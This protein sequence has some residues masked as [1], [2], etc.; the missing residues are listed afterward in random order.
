MRKYL[1]HI[2]T[3]FNLFC[4]CCAIVYVFNAQFITAFWLVFIGGIADYSDGLVARQ[5]NVKSALGKEL[6]SMADMVT[7]GIVPGVILYVLLASGEGPLPSGQVVLKALPAFLLSVFA[8]LRLARFNLD[9]R[10]TEDFIGLPTPATTVFVV[11]IMLIYEFDTYGLRQWVSNPALLYPIILLFSYLLVAEIP[12]F[13]L[14]FKGMRWKGNEKRFVFLGLGILLL[15]LIKEAAFSLGI[16]LY[17]LFS[18]F[19]KLRTRRS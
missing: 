14:K 6:D 15:F 5:L 1:P 12:M 8:G 18:V 3:L 7:F 19:D 11:G 13:S 10:Q 16:I 4:G 2:I 17:V 9:Q